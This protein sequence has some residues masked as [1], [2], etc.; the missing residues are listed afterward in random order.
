MASNLT[1]RSVK[2]LVPIIVASS[3]L[4]SLLKEQ[5]WVP[6]QAKQFAFYLLGPIAAV[7]M[8]LVIPYIR[9]RLEIVAPRRVS[10]FVLGVVIGI[11]VV[12]VVTWALM[13]YQVNWIG[14]NSIKSTALFFKDT[15]LVSSA[16]VF[17]LL[18][19]RLVRW[20]GRTRNLFVL[21]YAGFAWG[22]AVFAGLNILPDYV[23]KP[24]P[25]ISIQAIAVAF[26]FLMWTGSAALILLVRAYFRNI[27]LKLAGFF[28]VTP[29][30]I[31][32][33]VFMLSIIFQTPLETTTR[34]IALLG[35]AM[36]GPVYLTGFLLV[37][38][39]VQN[40]IAKEYY[41][42]LGYAL[43]LLAG[44]T[45]GIGL[46]VAPVFPLSG[47]PSLT[48]LAHGACLAFAAFTSAA[49][50]FSISEN[51]RKEIR[52]SKAFVTSI[53]EAENRISVERQVTAFYDR[54]TRMAEAS[55]AVEATAI[56]K[57]EIYSYAAAVK[58]M[59]RTGSAPPTTI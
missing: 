39:T 18:A 36:A 4:D 38:T 29:H 3:A 25:L 15:V 20:Y 30:G 16:V 59:G 12:A 6:N 55:G 9:A 27:I 45:C 13:Y 51:V 19:I 53:G 54:F 43:G 33:S 17:A 58:R 46:G 7:G 40:P 48:T 26:M 52:E 34:T 42:G 14:P 57:D 31:L 23:A 2:Y 47:F 50:Y 22:D 35:L 24:T 41:R 44:A 11:S 5:P 32:A 49:S 8:V 10:N 1:F 56:S 21:L 37:A 28:I